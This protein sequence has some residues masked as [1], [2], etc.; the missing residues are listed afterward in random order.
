MP[1]RI[2]RFA[3]SGLAAGVCAAANADVAIPAYQSGSAW[4][5]DGQSNVQ[6]KAELERT[7]A[8][9]KNVILFVGDGMGISTLTA[10][11]ILQG[12]LAGDEGE[13]P[14]L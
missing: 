8:T 1:N 7:A 10:A 13:L 14:V 12:Q 11:R 4:F 2:V 9:A 6:E 5:T 3:L